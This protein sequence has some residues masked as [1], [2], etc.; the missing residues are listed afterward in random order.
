MNTEFEIC[1]HCECENEFENIDDSV[2]KAK[3]KHCGQ[4]IMLCNK[5]YGL[6][7]GI[8]DWKATPTGGKCYRGC[9]KFD[10]NASGDKS[11]FR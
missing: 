3:C 5:C 9:T 8:C 11:N 10:A 6:N 4:E 2:F 1:P 7:G